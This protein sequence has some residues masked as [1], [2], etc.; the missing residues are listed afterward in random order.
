MVSSIVDDDGQGKIEE[1]RIE[2]FPENEC[3]LLFVARKNRKMAR[4]S[5]R[6][7]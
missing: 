2:I 3:H 6:S 5:W 1:D 4:T 7:S